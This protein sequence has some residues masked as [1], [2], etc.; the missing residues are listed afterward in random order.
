MQLIIFDLGGILVPEATDTIIYP[1]V[2]KFMGISVEE[3]NAA[4]ACFKLAVTE[5]VMSLKEMYVKITAK[6]KLK[7]SAEKVSEKHKE[8]YIKHSTTQDKDIID[9]IEKLKLHYEVVCLT[10]TELEIVAYNKEHGLFQY[11]EKAFLS[12]DLKLRKPQTEIYKK[13]CEECNCPAEEALFIDDNEEYTDGAAEAGLNV[14]LFHN[15][16][17]LI[18]DLQTLDIQM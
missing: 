18:K 8:L 16:K 11:F 13:V 6:F 1:E 2:A 7:I 15:K 14:I 10:N 3:F 12:T 5:G 4:I 9:L 17:Q